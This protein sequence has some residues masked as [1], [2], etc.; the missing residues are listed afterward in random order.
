MPRDLVVAR[1]VRPGRLSVAFRLGGL[2]DACAPPR[3]G[4]RR[5]HA[6]IRMTRMHVTRMHAFA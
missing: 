2:K 1:Y 3:G 6:R 5:A 4:G